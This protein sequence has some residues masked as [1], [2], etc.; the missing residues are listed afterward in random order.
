MRIILF[1]AFFLLGKIA[2]AQT[3]INSYA[4]VTAINGTKTT[5]TISTKYPT[6]HNFAANSEVIII[7]MQDN[8]IG[9]TNNEANFGTIGSIGS[10]GLYEVCKVQSFSGSTMVLTSPLKNTYNTGANSSVQIVSF[11]SYN[12][13]VFN[14]NVTALQ[15]DGNI[16]GVIALQST[17]WIRIGDGY[18]I[19]ANGL[20]FRGGVISD[21]NS[22]V[23]CNQSYITSTAGISGGKG[24]GIYKSTNTNFVHGRAK[25]LNGGGGGNLHN[26]G[27]GG[28]GNYSAGGAGGGGYGCAS[29]P[30]GGQGGIS[31]SA[32][33]TKDRVFMG[34][35]GGGGHQNN[36]HSSAGGNGGGIIFIK[37][38]EIRYWELRIR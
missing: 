28:G 3:I 34:G 23:E 29:N 19:S 13:Q 31:L 6:T 26:A 17:G 5:L 25:I 9:N 38:E 14:Y 1:I 10:A 4:K 32:Y 37:A 18:S 15:W 11:P 12:N 33:S 8:V 20:G 7:Q 2:H 16:G 30:V 35:G 36:G 24:E 22:T 21:A 27:G